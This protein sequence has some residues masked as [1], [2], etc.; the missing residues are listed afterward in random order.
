MCIKILNAEDHAKDITAYDAEAYIGHD[1]GNYQSYLTDFD[2]DTNDNATTTDI[3]THHI[4]HYPIDSSTHIFPMQDCTTTHTNTTKILQIKMNLTQQ[5][6]SG[7]NKNVTNDTKIIRN[8]TPLISTPVFGIGDD[9]VACHI[10][11]KGITTLLTIDGS[12]LDI[13]MYYAP[14]CSGTIISPNAIVRD[15]KSLT[16]WVQ[17]S[18]LDIGQAE[19]NFYHRNDCTRNRKILMHMNNDLGYLHQQYHKMVQAANRTRICVLR[20]FDDISP[21]LVHKLSKPIEYEL[22]HQRLMHP[23]STCMSNIDKCTAGVPVL[24]RHPMHNCK[25]CHEMNIAKNTSKLAPKLTVH[26]FGEQFQMD[27]GFMSAKVN[28]QI[29]TSHDGYK[30]YLLIVDLFTRYLWVFLS[31]NK[32]P[33]I[34]VMKQFLRTYGNKEGTRIIRTDQGGELARSALFRQ[35]LH[36]ASYSIEITGSDNSSQNGVAERPHR[37]LAN[38]VRTALET[39]NLPLKYWSDALLHAAF[40][41]NRL[42]HSEFNFKV[43]PYEKLTGITPDLSN[44]RVFGCRIVT[45]RPG[46]R[47]T[48][49]AKHSY[50]GIF[51]RFA[52]TMR[53]IVYLDTSTKKIKTTTYAKFDEAHFSHSDKPPG[54]KILIEMGLKEDDPTAISSTPPKLKI[55]KKH[56][57]AIVPQ[58]ASTKAAGFDLYSINDCIIPPSHVAVVDTGI[59]AQFPNNTYGR[60]ASRSGLAL[61]NYV[62]IKGG[63]IDPDYTGNIK[64]I[65]HNFGTTNFKVKKSDRIAQ[66]IL[67][68]YVSPS[69]QVTTKLDTSDRGSKG[70]GSTGVSNDV[71]STPINKSS[72]II[73]YESNE[74]NKNI[75][76]SANIMSLNGA[77]LQMVYHQPINITTIE[78]KKIG[79]HPT[80][81]FQLT[82][83]DKGPLI[84][85]CIR[86][87]PAAKIP[88]WRTFVRGA[89][90]YSINDIMVHTDSNIPTI[91]A[92]THGTSLKLSLIPP[93][94]TDIHPETGLPQLNFDQ[95]L[96]ISR[97]HQDILHQSRT[98]NYHTD[99]IDDCKVEIQKLS[100]RN[101]TR[102]QL[103][104][105]TD[106]KDWEESEKLQLDQY[107][108]Q[109]MFGKP[110]PIPSTITEYSILPMIWVYLVKVDGRK[111]ARC[112]ANGAPHLKGTITLANTYAAC[113]EQA[114]CRLFWSIAAIKNNKVF[115]ADAVNA[116]AEAPPPK[117]PLF[118]K[119]D[120]AYKNWYFNKTNLHLPDNSYVQ[121]FQAIQG[122]PESP[123]LWNLHIDSILSKIGFKSTTHEPCIYIT[124][125]TT[126]TIYLLRQVDDFAIACDDK[127]TATYYWDKLDE[128]L[129]EPLKRE[130]GLMR[131]HNGIDIEQTAH[132]IK[133]HCQTY[134]QRI[135]KS[136]TFDMT[137]KQHKPL[138][139]DSN[140]SYVKT[141]ES[142]TGPLTPEDNKI[143]ETNAGFKYRNTTG[144]LIFA[145]VT[146]RAD[147]AFSVI[148]LTQYNSKPATCHY[149]AVKQVFRYLQATISDGLQFWRP[150]PNSTLPT[151]KLPSVEQDTH[152]TQIPVESG[153][154]TTVYAYTDSDLAGDTATRKSVSGVTIFF[155]GAAVVYKTILQRTIALSSTEAEF[156]AITETGKLVL[157]IRHV[158]CDL[159]IE[160]QQPTAIY[161]DNRG[162]LQMTQALKPTKRTRHVDSRYFAILDWVQTDQI[163]VKKID[164]SDNAS[165]V[166][167]KATGRIIFY[168][169]VDTI[170][171]KRTPLY[172]K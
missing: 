149:D 117:S 32:H 103:L 162:C 160:Q 144:E 15:D 90:I 155:G 70:F 156:Y 61:N 134:L 68:Q 89:I 102:R 22:W 131:R 142:T 152:L 26:K 44:L 9:T 99:D 151:S 56:Q 163:I 49:L 120:M 130:S 166:L 143:L 139:M 111:K 20:D 27:F 159:N 141:L 95:F 101:L 30:C 64:V 105:Q 42:P 92:S 85:H 126:E 170:L 75:I 7:A 146:C 165:D 80:L 43:T 138:P 82:N 23:G 115:G 116:F 36:D 119:V 81:G 48:K 53:N 79:S 88:Q 136:K 96:H 31:K 59:A 51:L 97:L 128:H 140:S 73:P 37:S 10:T 133:M 132:G 14:K 19:I 171:G 161:E 118:L 172:V 83:D 108:R 24:H 167:T 33:P 86:G 58:Q 109:N 76:N 106:W 98:T 66:M 129:K 113:L 153:H 2:N 47:S 72:N 57:D 127:S 5:M 65:L 69:V 40:V 52:K 25:I 107:E 12:T 137:I 148:K 34:K 55:V 112:V 28:Q 74:I 135:L 39:S 41:K 84:T 93:A 157:Y 13:N 164:T 45:R 158:L 87:T 104:Q 21:F 60:I 91:I 63:V 114:A 94:P 100:A 123:R 50:T 11:G 122:H 18:H 147:I 29:I 168:R 125:T 150:K 16:S 4:L 3:S 78:V 62:E 17:T 1:D 67:E 169:H 71:D 121:V 6:D 110:G 54:A 8:F 145:M 38:M 77:T 46:R 35:A 124:Y 154:H